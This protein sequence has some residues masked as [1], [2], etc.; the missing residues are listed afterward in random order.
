MTAAGA[1]TLR[2]SAM[3]AEPPVGVLASLQADHVVLRA[4]LGNRDLIALLLRSPHLW[5]AR[6]AELSPL[7][8]H[9]GH[10]ASEEVD[11]GTSAFM[12]GER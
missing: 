7:D 2:T 11:H 12:R 10:S 4:D 5:R 6:A 9:V 8:T 3:K 1:P